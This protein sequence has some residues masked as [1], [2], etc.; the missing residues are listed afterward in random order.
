MIKTGDES[1]TIFYHTLYIKL[2]NFYARLLLAKGAAKDS[3]CL[4][5]VEAL[6][7]NSSEEE[8]WRSRRWQFALSLDEVAVS[9]S[10]SVVSSCGRSRRSAGRRARRGLC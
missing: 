7:G 2:L 8:K 1:V 4:V 9:V 6:V 10:A 3:A 5:A